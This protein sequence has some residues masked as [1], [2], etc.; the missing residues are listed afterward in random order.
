MKKSAKIS[1]ASIG[2]VGAGVGLV[3]LSGRSRWNGETVELIETLRQSIVSDRTK[4]V[5][6]LAESAWL[7]TAL[8]PSENLKWSA[9]D[10]R[11]ASATLTDSGTTVSLEFRFNDE[12]EIVEV[13]TPARFREAGGKYESS[14]WAGRFWSYAERNGMLI[15][16][17]GEVEWQPPDGNLPYW[18]GQIVEAEYD[19]AN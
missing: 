16:N 10:D 8:L 13:F 3:F 6:F 2:L 11:R 5:S 17:D 1:L 12:S 18:R 7:P 9:I 19:F 15:P 14:A 4:T